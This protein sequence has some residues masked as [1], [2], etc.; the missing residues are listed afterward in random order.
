LGVVV[1]LERKKRPI[2][3]R[4]AALVMENEVDGLVIP[5]DLSPSVAVSVLHDHS[6]FDIGERSAH[7]DLSVFR[8]V[9]DSRRE[10]EAAQSALEPPVRLQPDRGTPND[11]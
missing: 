10:W 8:G 5:K 2:D 7:A 3:M 1:Q 11:T 9:T 4:T 6:P